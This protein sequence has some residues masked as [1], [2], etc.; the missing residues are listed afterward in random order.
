MATDDFP[1]ARRFA[2]VPGVLNTSE[3]G[4]CLRPGSFRERKGWGAGERLVAANV[5]EVRG[6]ERRPV[7]GRDV[8]RGILDSL[9]CPFRM[10]DADASVNAHVVNGQMT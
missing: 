1:N 2:F 3:R 7:Q 8:C 10:H 4:P 6:R 5:G 9:S